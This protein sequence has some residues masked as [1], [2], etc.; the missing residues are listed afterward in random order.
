MVFSPHMKLHK[1]K[2]NTKHGLTLLI[3]KDGTMKQ[4]LLS[5][6]YKTRLCFTDL[7]YYYSNIN[8][9]P[10]NLIYHNYIITLMIN[11]IYDEARK[12][13]KDLHNEEITFN[14]LDNDR[15]T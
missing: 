8:S 4:I 14:F 7:G 2:Y 15:A 6:I 1:L 3:H 12:E 11:S 10:S 13:Y 9:F 5:G